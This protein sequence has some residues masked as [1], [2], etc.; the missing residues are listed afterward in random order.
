MGYLKSYVDSKPP[1][2]CGEQHGKIKWLV[3]SRDEAII[4]EPLD[5]ALAISLEDNS[6]PVNE[7]VGRYVTEKVEGLVKT[8]KYDSELRAFVE[9]HLRRTANGTFLWVA[10][11]CK[12]LEHPGVRAATTKKVLLDL[13]AG[14]APMYDRILGQ[15]L[16]NPDSEYVEE[17]LKAVL[18]A[19]RQLN[20]SELAVAARL[21]KENRHDTQYVK[22]CV[23]QCGSLLSIHK[24]TGRVSLIHQSAKDYLAPRHCLTPGDCRTLKDCPTPMYCIDPEKCRCRRNCLTPK[25]CQ[26][27][28]KCHCPPK[29]FTP[30]SYPSPEDCGFPI[31]AAKVHTVVA[32]R[33][34]DYLADDDFSQKPLEMLP[35]ADY[36]TI[37]WLS[38]GKDASA[39]IE[40]VMK[41]IS[42]DELF[43]RDVEKGKLWLKRYKRSRY[44]PYFPEYEK[45]FNALH[46]AACTGIA[47]FVLVV[48]EKG[49]ELDSK[50]YRGETALHWTA[51]N[52]HSAVMMLLLDQGADVDA[53]DIDGETALQWAA[54]R[55]QEAA[56]RLLLDRG[57]DVDAKNKDG[58]TALWG[59]VA[60]RG[61]EAVVRLLLDRGADV[62]AKDK[63][64]RTALWRA[65]AE[66]GDEAMVRLLLDR[67]A[68]VD[69][70]DIDGKTALWGTVVM[71]GQE[72]V[73]RLLLDRGADV[74][75]KD[76][77]GT[78]ALLC[79]ARWGQ[80]A[81]VRLL[82]DR[83]ADIDARDNDGATA[84]WGAAVMRGQEAVVRLLLDRGVD[85]DAKD[86]Y[87]RTAL[88]VAVSARQEAVVQLLTPLTSDS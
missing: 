65:A 39:E 27:G 38:H 14:L 49:A 10:L 62:D 36:A 54:V 24:D 16:A 30:D 58:K 17:I 12:E 26:Y 23:L 70:K 75:V 21:P 87:G 81:V 6:Q 63:D 7:A 52:G 13:P 66:R 60:M 53:K 44:K 3:T 67:G 71:R 88:Q 50:D 31:D 18:V 37:F 56:V 77:N 2:K 42:V 48:L 8:K 57:A 43:F 32:E 78:T 68:D 33:C 51:Y 79:V 19:F 85:V 64:G 72:A 47:Q 45:G 61:Q 15:A 55:G 80:E 74:D 69:V 9:K 29:C 11:A 40:N 25:N 28:K 35:F 76:K 34:L 4:R 84:L 82:L 73:V 59:A 41:G 1:N 86:K 5:G 46:V 83:G 22:D 20:L